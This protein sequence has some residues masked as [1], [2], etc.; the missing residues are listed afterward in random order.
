MRAL[1]LAG[2]LGS[3]LFLAAC[4]GSG[5]SLTA[6][7]K[8]W[9]TEGL[10]LHEKFE[11]ANKSSGSQGAAGVLAALVSVIGAPNELARLMNQMAAVAP[12][13]VQPDFEAVGTAFRKLS[14][15]ESKAFTDPLG[16]LGGSLVESL[17]VSGSF[18]RVNVFLGTNCGIPKE[19]G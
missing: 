17:S 9:D 6:V 1:V 14:E 11:N 7:C 10:A 16:A 15:S 19:K 13:N 4:G 2:V 8:V 5:R 18:S 12:P 3:C